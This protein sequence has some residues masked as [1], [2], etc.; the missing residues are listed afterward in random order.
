M[1]IELKRIDQDFGFEAVNADGNKVALDAAPTI[2]GHSQG[3]RPMELLL[4]GVAGCSAID[5]IHILR[6]QRQELESLEITVDGERQ[7]DVEP[8]LFE[9]IQITFHL[10]GQTDETKILRA[11]KLSMDKYCSVSK[12]LEQSATI[13][14]QTIYNGQPLA[15]K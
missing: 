14:Y 9:T 6:K 15:D 12:I 5:I 10:K 4:M 13:T 1:R 2:G 11:V 7:K 8:A 3:A